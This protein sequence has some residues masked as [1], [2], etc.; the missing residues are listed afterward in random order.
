MAFLLL[1][2]SFMMSLYGLVFSQLIFLFFI[3]ASPRRGRPVFRFLGLL[4]SRFLLFFTYSLCIPVF[5]CDSFSRVFFDLT[6]EIT[7]T[8]VYN[9]SR[10]YDLAILYI[11]TYL[12]SNEPS[13]SISL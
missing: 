8:Y 1:L 12:Q 9:L 13:E 2:Y 5:R 3:I 11:M 7:S 10:L 4:F 6:L